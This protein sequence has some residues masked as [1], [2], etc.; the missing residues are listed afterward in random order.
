M[1]M[2]RT[3]WILL[4]TLACARPAAAQSQFQSTFELGLGYTRPATE[5]IDMV[6][7]LL[8]ADDFFLETG[9][10]VRV[11]GGL[12]GDTMF[13]WL[14]RGAARPFLIGSTSGHI[15]AE[16]SLHTNAT[17]DADGTSTLVGLGFLIGA[18]HPITDHLNF[19]VHLSPI[20]FEFGGSDTI[21]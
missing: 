18:S 13:S 14:V 8:L 7:A 11:N 16:F 21:T 2:K 1:E 17:A 10:G 3:F 6:S 9:I 5:S 20:P 4:A 15:G 19:A 12:N